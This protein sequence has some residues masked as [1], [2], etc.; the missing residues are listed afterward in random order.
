MP[1]KNDFNDEQNDEQEPI[2][3]ARD[4]LGADRNDRDHLDTNRIN[5]DQLAA[6]IKTA[7]STLSRAESWRDFWV[8]FSAVCHFI[9]SYGPKIFV[10]LAVSQEAGQTDTGNITTGIRW[11][12]LFELIMHILFLFFGCL[13]VQANK[14]VKLHVADLAKKVTGRI[15]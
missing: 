5:Q 7:E 11:G 13:V 4:E 12:F 6:N 9:S 14:N 8:F 15:I 2:L 10:V 1:K 3:A